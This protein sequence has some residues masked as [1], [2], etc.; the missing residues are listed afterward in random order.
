MS[1]HTVATYKHAMV[2]IGKNMYGGAFDL[3]M[4]AYGHEYK[5]HI[6][7][8][9]NGSNAMITYESRDDIIM[10]FNDPLPKTIRED[11]DAWIVYEYKAALFANAKDAQETLDHHRETSIDT[12]RKKV[13]EHIDKIGLCQDEL[14]KAYAGEGFNPYVDTNE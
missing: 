2:D 8:I 12:L 10:S 9:D 3:T 13:Q 7:H 14:E 1:E 6:R 4:R 11:V 5:V